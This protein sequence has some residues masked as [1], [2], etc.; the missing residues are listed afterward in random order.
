MY[1]KKH[2]NFYINTDYIK[3]NWY[4]IV[5]KYLMFESYFKRIDGYNII[6]YHK[7]KIDIISYLY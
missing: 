6:P 5:D 4:Q 1:S 3:N 7:F 2:H